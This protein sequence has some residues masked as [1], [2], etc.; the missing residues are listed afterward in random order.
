MESSELNNDDEYDYEYYDGERSTTPARPTSPPKK[1]QNNRNKPKIVTQKFNFNDDEYD[2]KDESTTKRTFTVPRH[3]FTDFASLQEKLRPKIITIPSPKFNGKVITKQKPKFNDG[4]DYDDDDD[5]DYDYQGDFDNDRRVKIITLTTTAAPFKFE[6]SRLKPRPKTVTNVRSKPKAV[7]KQFHKSNED[8]DQS[9]NFNDYDDD[10]T[11]ISSNPNVV[12]KQ[13]KSSNEDYD[14][15]DDYD[16]DKTVKK[17]T[18]P[19]PRPQPRGIRIKEIVAEPFHNTL[20]DEDYDYKEYDEDVLEIDDELKP[21]VV[22]YKY[23]LPEFD[24]F[25]GLIKII[26]PKF[27]RRRKDQSQEVVGLPPFPKFNDFGRKV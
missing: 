21:N 14:Y 26:N 9:D 24:T 16:D 18:L 20:D 2:D 11:T 13:F 19:S 22:F 27:E 8:Y 17:F 3:H 4:N 10:K 23:K 7:T 6:S 1:I 25:P 15:N 12:R 5:D